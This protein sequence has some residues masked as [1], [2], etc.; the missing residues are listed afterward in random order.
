ML[1]LP[2]NEIL[3]HATALLTKHSTTLGVAQTLTSSLN[4][5]QREHFLRQQLAAV[6][7]ELDALQQGNH[8]GV[9]GSGSG[10]GVG[11]RGN[12]IGGGGGGEWDASMDPEGDPDGL[13]ELKQKIEKLGPGTEERRVAISEWKRLKRIPN[14]SVEWGIVRG[15]VCSSFYFRLHRNLA[16]LTRRSWI[17][18]RRSRGRPQRRSRLKPWCRK[19]RA[20]HSFWQQRKHSSTKTIMGLIV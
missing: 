8:S 20:R 6:R 18:S 2:P 3:A 5:Q 17:G 10:G 4:R 19:R 12:A 16:D 9:G 15:Y 13:L 7:A 1:S 14:A 11:G